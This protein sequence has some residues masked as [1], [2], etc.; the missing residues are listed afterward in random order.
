MDT[1]PL[2]IFVDIVFLFL[3]LLVL[4]GLTTCIFNLLKVNF[5]CD[6]AA[7]YLPML[8]PPQEERDKDEV[9]RGAGDLACMPAQ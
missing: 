5:T 4:W 3:R 7:P 2:T 9:V 1:S 6:P 8:I